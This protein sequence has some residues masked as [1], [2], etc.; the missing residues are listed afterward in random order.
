MDI[1]LCLFAGNNDE[2]VELLRLE[3][4]K[5]SSDEVVYLQT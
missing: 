4:I 3:A 2:Y 1:A 5:V